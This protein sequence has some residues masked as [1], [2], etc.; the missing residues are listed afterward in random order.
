MRRTFLALLATFALTAGH[1]EAVTV[2][3]LIEL[4]KAGLSDPVLLAL[5]DAEHS[6]FAIDAATIKQLKEGGVSDDVILAVIHSGRTQRTEPARA[7]I[8][9]PD[10][11]PRREPEVIVI[12]HHDAPQTPPAPVAY[13]APM[14][15]PVPIAVPVYV[16]VPSRA[17]DPRATNRGSR[18]IQT[19]VSTDQ[20]DVKARLPLPPN[21]VKAQPIYWGFGGQLRP[22][23]YQPPPL[24]ICR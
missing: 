10:P 2:R 16:P 22:G 5:I 15:Y 24:T 20:G 12:D 23:S 19:T 21:C 13:P 6:V 18:T 14:A 1:A 4:S 3:D 7:P 11:E 17:F 8:P 9:P